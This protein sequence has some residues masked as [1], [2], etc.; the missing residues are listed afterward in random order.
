MQINELLDVIEYGIK[1]YR[2]EDLGNRFSLLEY[3]AL[4]DI[5]PTDLSKIAYR[6]KRTGTGLALRIFN[7]KNF[8]L[9]QK[10]DMSSKLRLKHSVKG[11]ELTPDD[12]L[13]IKDTIE[14]EGYPLIDGVFDMIARHY[15]NQGIES[16]TKDIISAQVISAY[17]NAKGIKE[18]SNDQ[19]LY[20]DVKPKLLMK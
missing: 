9:S 7:D 15:V 4:T 8:W 20:N 5:R 10:L 3:Y 11:R 6:Q 13:L 17:N 19:F 1:F 2:N 12:K 18:T 14:Q 16:V